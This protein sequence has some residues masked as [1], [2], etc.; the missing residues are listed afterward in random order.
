MS[1]KYTYNSNAIDD[2]AASWK[3][4]PNNLLIVMSSSLQDIFDVLSIIPLKRVGTHSQP[5]M[6]EWTNDQT[7]R[8]SKQSVINE[9]VLY[10]NW[11]KK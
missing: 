3:L 11:N 7:K 2:H 8:T 5:A 6:S 9:T 10:Q 1:V 4:Y